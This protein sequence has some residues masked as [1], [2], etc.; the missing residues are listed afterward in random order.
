M[1]SKDYIYIFMHIYVCNNNS[2]TIKESNLWIL[3]IPMGV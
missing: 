3:K 1:D 2:L